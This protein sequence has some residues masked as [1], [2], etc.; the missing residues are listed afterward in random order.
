MTLLRSLMLLALIAWIGG[1]I[2]FAFV[3]APTVFS[4]LPTREMAGNVVNPSL[5]ALHWIGLVAGVIFLI[6]SLFLGRIQ[7]ARFKPATLVHGL[8]VLMLALTLVSQ[9][10]ISPRMSSLRSEM[11]VI[12]NVAFSDTRRVE[13]NRLHQWSTRSEVGVLLCG[14]LVVVLT[15]RQRG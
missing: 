10:A 12:D 13:F 8:A 1:I 7:Y 15:A 4:V 5:T 9:F 11:G 3:L 2:F 6:C 14:L